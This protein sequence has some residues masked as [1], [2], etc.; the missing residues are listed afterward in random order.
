[1]SM[2][3][4]PPSA[5]RVRVLAIIVCSALLTSAAFALPPAPPNDDPANAETIG[6]DVPIVVFG[7]TVLADDSISATTLPPPADDVDGPDVFYSFTPNVSD[8]Y[9]VHL[10]PWQRAPLRSSD[11]QFTIYIQDGDSIFL[12]GARAGGTGRNVYFDVS[13]AAGLTYRIGVDYNAATH[14]NFPFTLL[15][16]LLS[17]VAPDKCVTA[18]S[19]ST[20]LPTVAL[21]DIDGALPDYFF[22]QGTGQCAVSGAT[23]TTAPGN[24]HVFVFEPTVTGEYAFELG[25][26]G[27]DG[28]LY[29]NTSCPP[30]F[31][32]G[33][34]GASNH[35]TSGSSGGKHE[36]IVVTLEAGTPYYIYVDNGS[37]TLT[38]GAYALIVDTAFGYEIS[39]VEPNDD[40]IDATP[41]TTPLNGGQ[42]VGPLDEDWW[43][44][45]GLTGDKVY[46]WANNGGSSNSTLDT[47]LEFYAPNG[48]TLLEFDDEDGDGAD[49]PIE[50]LRYVYSTTSPVIAGA[51]MTADG[52]HYFV[53][54]DQ[55]AIGTVHRYRMHTGVEPATRAPLP[56][57]EPNDTLASADFTGKHYYAGVIDQ[58]GDVDYYAF[59][60]AVGDRVFIAADGD[61]ERDS[62]GM[63]SPTTDPKAFHAKLVVYDPAGDI[64]IGDVSD[65]NSVQSGP[66]YPAQGAFFVARTEG[67]HYVSVA[68]QSAVSQVGPEET[69][70]VAV[71]VN[72]DAPAMTDESDPV[73]TQTPD[74]PGNLID[75]LAEDDQPGDSGI[76]SA[77]LVDATNLQ[78]TGLVFTP[79][80]PTADFAV[81]LIN[82][83]D[84][85]FGKL[86]VADCAGNTVCQVVN[87]DVHPP[88]CDG[89]N[90]SN[91][92]PYSMHGPIHVPDNEPTGPGIDGTIE[93][94][95]PGLV[96][97]VN[98]TI[99]IETV[100]PPDMDVFLISPTG[101][102]VELITDRGS[103][104][105][106]DITDATFDDDAEEIMSIMSGDAPYT[107]TWLPEDPQGLAKLIGE[108]A[109]GTWRLNVRDDSSSGGGG[110]RLARWSLD[111]DAGFPGPESFAGTVSDT[112]GFDAGIDTI[113]LT[114][115]VNAELTVSPEFV[116]GDLVVDYLVTLIDPDAGGSGTVAVTDLA[117]NTCQSIITLNGLPDVTAPVSAGA[118]S[119]DWTFADEVQADVPG[120]DPS[121]VVRSVS[122]PT[123]LLVG[124]VEV[125]LTVDTLDVGRLAS[126]LTHGAEFASLANRI[127][128]DDRG[129][130][131]LTK[132]NIE[133]TLDDDAPQADD[134]HDEPASGAIELLGLHQPDGRG[135]AIGDGITTD[136]R[137][138]M[139]FVLSNKD[140]VGQWDLFVGDFRIQGAGS[141]HSTF[142]RWAMTIKSPCGAEHYV[143]RAIDFAPGSGIC[144]VELGAGAVN[145]SAGATFTPGDEVVDYEVVLIDP[146]VA[147][148]GT[149]EITDC[150]SNVEFVAID[151]AAETGDAVAPILTGAVN[152]STL[153]FEGSASDQG[154]GDTG[155]VAVELA[156]YSHNLEILSI[157]PSIP[158]GGVG[159]VDF[160]VGLINPTEGGRGYIRATD[161]CGLR[162]HILVH[163][164]PVGPACTGS[165]SHT[166]RYIS[167]DDLP[168]PI[169]DN[170]ASGVVSTINVPDTDIISDVDITFNITH[171][172]DDDI[173]FRLT[174]PT[175]RDLF[176]DIGLTGN[177]FIDTTLDDEA[178]SPIPDSSSEAPFTGSYQPEGGPS[179]FVLDGSPAA[180]PYTIQ[181]VDDAQYNVGSLD[182]WSVTIESPTYPERYDGR[183][184][185]SGTFAS[186][187]CSVELLPGAV[188]MTLA[189]DPFIGGDAIVR[190][191]I[192]LGCGAGGAG[193]GEVRVTDCAGNICDIPVTLTPSTGC[194]LAD[195]TCVDA[196]PACCA[197]LG[198]TPLAT[199]C[200]PAQACCFADGSCDDLDPQCCVGLGGTPAAPGQ[201]CLGDNNGDG[202]DDGCSPTAPAMPRPDD[203]FD[204]GGT[205]V[206]CSTD[207]DCRA[208][209]N[210][211]SSVYCLHVPPGSPDP[212]V[213]YV[214]RNRYLSIAPNPDNA[215]LLTARRVSLYDLG[216]NN[217]FLGWIAEPVELAVAGPEATPQLLARIES[218]PH[219]RDWS[220]DNVGQPWMNATVH[221]GDC[222]TSP[223]RTYVI[224]AI[225]ENMNV[226]DEANYSDALMLHTTID[227]GD[228]VGGTPGTPP[229]GNRNFKDISA[230]VRGFQSTQSEPKTWLDL[231]GGNQTP[232]IPDFTDINFKDIDWAVAGFQGGSYP[233]AAPQDC[234]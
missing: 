40:A 174:A 201:L 105:A 126:T 87:I 133:V 176:S 48:S 35:S 222:E 110:A 12:A 51:R 96:Y 93:I 127:G 28:V 80:D 204:I 138:N 106:F 131:G 196:E 152:P 144:S 34:L 129:S 158:P 45:T 27:F 103:S 210:P 7:T 42:L 11:R 52:D 230:V 64:L 89:V 26:A 163:I 203:A 71:F 156:P 142:R 37:T 140:A 124:E 111:I 112:Q 117:E 46:A 60:T 21:N 218:A 134:I 49:A 195:G 61:P 102:S 160:V 101:T 136:D 5:S 8:V 66:D 67:T 150:D 119:T 82:P 141:A 100:R 88:V 168:A 173:D 213:C 39:E 216:G 1:M 207:D 59:K 97:D 166:K 94:N 148:T 123:S 44:V 91:R 186:G 149:L 187:I 193:S 205:V 38:T 115:A 215:G 132:N 183:A 10:M 55:S 171:G 78:L 180:G 200:E 189:V 29:V 234:P 153:E 53:V 188:N 99:S 128:M 211:S 178:P 190:Y 95:E 6:P 145:L 104:L 125:D 221:V 181:V 179:L 177:D 226:D 86:L 15:V 154:P 212:G 146:A 76:C 175:F 19:L 57:C 231:Q 217:I 122:I 167:S 164:D 197:S 199:L 30:V 90:F 9:R 182:S 36:L 23:P 109:Q 74:Y 18:E 194:C 114:G 68:A 147:G 220:V 223:G 69:Y 165:I 50:D 62:T 157:V 43:A 113:V 41:L 192:E 77:Q 206:P 14:D 92:S 54:T 63:E 32:G 22:V 139:L 72:E 98:V 65:S 169:P 225:A 4:L 159:S 229:D 79:G 20:D 16:D 151:L 214:A 2:E 118:A 202:V 162:E 232:D 161:L 209:L 3:P 75:V 233:F 219:Y 108:D 84:S 172:F 208:G 85:G 143:G 47:D 170:N 73:M 184:E 107:G 130:V 31:P 227:F 155:V 135:Q 191:S 58:V 33:C 228:V 70:E 120:G 24:D 17:A 13:L 121:G 83:A 81:E 116:P 137:D 224:Q 198:G 56:E 185:D 25:T